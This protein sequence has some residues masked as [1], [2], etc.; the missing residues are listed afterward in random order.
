MQNSHERQNFESGTK[1]LEPSEELKVSFVETLPSELE[2]EIKEASPSEAE[3]ITALRADLVKA[4]KPFRESKIDVK[5]WPRSPRA[6]AV[7]LVTA[8]GKG[9]K[10][11]IRKYASVALA[12]LGLS[13]G[14]KLDAQTTNDVDQAAA[15]GSVTNITEKAKSPA[16][17]EKPFVYEEQ[18]GVEHWKTTT[19]ETR[20]AAEK[21]LK[22]KSSGGSVFTAPNVKEYVPPTPTVTPE[23]P[24][25]AA[26]TRR[27]SR[28]PENVRRG[29][30]TDNGRYRPPL[31]QVNTY[32][33]QPRPGEKVR[34]DPNTGKYIREWRIGP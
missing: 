29:I 10:N 19:P 4:S 7:D 23:N 22:E 13:G 12:A 20:A 32:P 33:P 30:E 18:Y 11:L 1:S 6:D 3:R 16:P 21:R 24:G 2:L 17:T 15:T 31:V 27:T 25:P 5:D 9:F 14:S 8:G 26:K 34:Y 28:T